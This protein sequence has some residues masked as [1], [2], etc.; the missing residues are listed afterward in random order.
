MWF[1]VQQAKN[2]EL[3]IDDK[4]RLLSCIR[5]YVWFKQHP[6]EQIGDHWS[7]RLALKFID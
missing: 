4:S 2:K 7:L 3:L 5:N 6:Y 1:S